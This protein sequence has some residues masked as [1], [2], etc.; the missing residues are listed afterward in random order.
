MT[1]GDTNESGRKPCRYCKLS[2]HSFSHLSTSLTLWLEA[3]KSVVAPRDQRPISSELPEL[4]LSTVEEMTRTDRA[5]RR[6][7]LRVP[8]EEGERVLNVRALDQR[9]DVVLNDVRGSVVAIPAEVTGDTIFTV[10]VV[11]CHCPWRRT[12]TRVSY[13][14]GFSLS[15]SPQSRASLTESY[16]PTTKNLLLQ[17]NSYESNGQARTRPRSIGRRTNRCGSENT[18]SS[19][20]NER[21][22]RTSYDIQHSSQETTRQACRARRN[23]SAKSGWERRD[24]LDSE[25]LTRRDLSPALVR[26]PPDP[27]LPNFPRVNQSLVLQTIQI[28][29]STRNGDVEVIRYIR[30]PNRGRVFARDVLEYLLVVQLRVRAGFRTHLERDSCCSGI[31]YGVSNR[32]SRIKVKWE[33]VVRSG[34]DSQ[35]ADRRRPENWRRTCRKQVRRTLGVC[36]TMWKQ[37]PYVKGLSGR[38]PA[39]SSLKLPLTT[40]STPSTEAV[41]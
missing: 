36:S 7:H 26:Q 13:H 22:R 2:K 3:E 23:R 21:R 38:S 17:K 27:H 25:R 30:S 33:G 18:V 12:T 29:E 15:E 37:E 28:V 4:R 20:S 35:R 34:Y 14:P 39:N 8:P 5:L 31:V 16:N 6:R 1:Q 9:I 41:A 24:I 40:N 10:G 11:S 32:Y 19:C